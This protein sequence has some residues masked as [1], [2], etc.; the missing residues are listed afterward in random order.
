[1]L[2]NQ[3]I[4]TCDI[5]P[6]LPRARP[7]R[8]RLCAPA[9]VPPPPSPALPH[10]PTRP[11]ARPTPPTSPRRSAARARRRAP[12]GVPPTAFARRPAHTGVPPSPAPDTRGLPAPV[13][14]RPPLQAR[15]PRPSP[16]QHCPSPLGV[17]PAILGAPPTAAAIL[18]SSPA[19]LGRP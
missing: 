8:A 10:P 15:G 17:T 5:R 16:W 9:G 14:P 4:S 7:A 18:S 1:M 19:R 12:A 11:P 3:D 6:A 13:A 2:T